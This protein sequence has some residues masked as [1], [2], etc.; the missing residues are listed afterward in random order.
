MESL[1]KHW[2]S[3]WTYLEEIRTM[4]KLG[5]CK[6]ALKFHVNLP[7]WTTL[8]QGSDECPLNIIQPRPIPFW[9]IRCQNVF[10]CVEVSWNMSLKIC[11]NV[12][13]D[14]ISKCRYKQELVRFWNHCGQS[15]DVSGLFV[16]KSEAGKCSRL[17]HGVGYM[18]TLSCWLDVISHLSGSRWRQLCKYWILTKFS[19]LIYD[20]STFVMNISSKAMMT[21]KI[22]ND[23]DVFVQE[24][25][26]YAGSH[27]H[28]ERCIFQILFSLAG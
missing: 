24:K 14:R 2:P 28:W 25:I 26:H 22:L 21:G 1:G 7:I 4:G 11:W 8:K 3:F 17:V 6:S 10:R 27:R 12:S 23:G 20:K 19:L 5:L 13:V 9:D 15:Y 16:W 18:S